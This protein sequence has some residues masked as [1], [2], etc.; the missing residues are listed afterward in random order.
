MVLVVVELADPIADTNGTLDSSG[1]DFLANFVAQDLLAQVGH[2]RSIE[3]RPITD[4]WTISAQPRSFANTGRFGV[5]GSRSRR[6]LPSGGTIGP[7]EEII[8]A[9]SI[10]GLAGTNDTRQS[11]RING[12]QSADRRQVAGHRPTAQ[13]RTIAAGKNAC[14]W[15]AGHGSVAQNR[16]RGN[17]TCSKGR[18]ATENRSRSAAT[19]D[20]SCGSGSGDRL[21]DDR[22]TNDRS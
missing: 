19:D 3:N 22:L 17:W 7:A 20:R 15:A 9:V 12:R 1:D 8:Q 18:S 14:R 16:A 5:A 10:N 11:R 13:D 2:D 4:D 21:T 6:Q